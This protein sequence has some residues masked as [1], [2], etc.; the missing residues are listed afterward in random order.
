MKDESLVKAIIYEV[1]SL[2]DNLDNMSIAD[3]KAKIMEQYV[4]AS[5]RLVNLF[6]LNTQRILERE[7]SDLKG[8]KK[9]ESSI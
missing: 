6:N 1:K 7:I 9:D 5:K 8:E 2:R 3:S 4:F